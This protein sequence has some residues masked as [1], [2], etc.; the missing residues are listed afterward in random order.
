MVDAWEGGEPRAC[1]HLADTMTHRR[2]AKRN[3][4]AW[5]RMRKGGRADQGG[6][7]AG[8]R[9]PPSPLSATEPQLPVPCPGWAWRGRDPHFQL[10][11]KSGR[12]PTPREPTTP[13]APDGTFITGLRANTGVVASACRPSPNFAQLRQ[14]RGGEHLRTS[15]RS[16]APLLIDRTWGQRQARNQHR[17]IF[18]HAEA[19][20][21]MRPSRS[22][23]H[24][25][26]APR[27]L[28]ARHLG[29]TPRAGVMPERPTPNP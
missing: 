23:M 24:G 21:R 14:A 3:Y 2:C 27:H 22:A 13:S 20:M 17:P 18:P 7:A 5:L 19:G 28:P 1:A 10:R 8:V 6:R 26:L 9:V 11:C 4:G 29:G 15:R 16:P 12:Q 25:G